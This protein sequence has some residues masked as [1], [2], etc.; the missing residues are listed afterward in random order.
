MVPRPPS[1]RGRES[2]GVNAA[3]VT[4]VRTPPIFDLLGSM[5]ALDRCSKCY[6]ITTGGRERNNKRGGP[7]QYLKCVDAH[8]R[9]EGD[10]IVGEM[11]EKGEGRGGGLDSFES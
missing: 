3:G 2:I 4:G 6:I 5:K 1:H 10:W 9:K 8:E 11:T 7:P